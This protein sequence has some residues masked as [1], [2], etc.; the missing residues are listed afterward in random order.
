MLV[1]GALVRCSQTNLRHEK[2]KIML[3]DSN[4]FSQVGHK[5][6]WECKEMGLKLHFGS[7]SFVGV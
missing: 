3:M 4:T 7:W 2:S 1:V 5:K 6:M